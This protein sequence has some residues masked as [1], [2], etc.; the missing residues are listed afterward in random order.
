M[1]NPTSTRPA[2]RGPLSPAKYGARMKS[3]MVTRAHGRSAAFSEPSGRRSGLGREDRGAR[4]S[5][6][7]LRLVGRGPGLPADGA[8]VGGRGGDACRRRVAGQLEDLAGID[9]VRILDLV[10]VQP[11]D[12]RPEVRIA[13]VGLREIPE[14]V[15]ALDGVGRRIGADFLRAQE[16]GGTHREE[17]GGA[18]RP[19]ESGNL[20]THSRAAAPERRMGNDGAPPSVGVLVGMTIDPVRGYRARYAG[21][22]GGRRD[23]RQRRPPISPP[24]R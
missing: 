7:L 23:A 24:S 16:R 14:G 8:G 5:A 19:A 1:S 9:P 3:P 17:G 13:E 12:L 11:V 10:R 22:A 4:G 21:Q 20:H 15:S 2:P 6:R 18:E